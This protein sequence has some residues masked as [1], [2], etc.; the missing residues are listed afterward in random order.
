MNFKS[1]DSK[2]YQEQAELAEKILRGPWELSEDAEQQLK[3]KSERA[4]THK[5]IEAATGIKFDV[6]KETAPG[7]AAFVTVKEREAYITEEV[8]DDP[9]LAEHAAHHEAMHLDT[10]MHLPL[11]KLAAH[12]VK[13]LC[14]ALDLSELSEEELIEGFNELLTIKE[15]GQ[16]DKIAYLK[17]EVPLAK[18]L[19]DLAE[20]FEIDSLAKAFRNANEGKFMDLLALLGDQL[21][22]IQNLKKVIN[23]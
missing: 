13:A 19:E 6:A 10:L 1:L 16:H 22:F 4:R 18:K 8:L 3:L 23:Q 7:V 9:K 17:H 20:N 14:Q 2:D 12:Q 5:K 11:Q 21:Y 15:H